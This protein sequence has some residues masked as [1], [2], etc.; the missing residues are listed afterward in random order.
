MMALDSGNEVILLLLDYS[1]AFDTI[2]SLVILSRL[3][4]RYGI[5]GN[6]LKLLT[7]LP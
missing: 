7:F 4:K 1:G 3:D 6:A 2:S 5:G